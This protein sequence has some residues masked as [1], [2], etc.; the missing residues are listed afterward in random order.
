VFVRLQV[1]DDEVARV[2]EEALKAKA[3]LEEQQRV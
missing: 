2:K 1:F 3:A